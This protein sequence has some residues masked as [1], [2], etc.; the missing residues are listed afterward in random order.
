MP[1]PLRASGKCLK[2]SRVDVN[3]YIEQAMAVSGG[4]KKFS[5]LDGFLG[6]TFRKKTKIEIKI[7]ASGKVFQGT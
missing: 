7:V 1:S 6:K 2:K 4:E 3:A 5:N